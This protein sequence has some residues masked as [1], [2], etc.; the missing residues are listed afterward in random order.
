MDLHI[1]TV[2]KEI[3]KY[4]LRHNQLLHNHEN[5]GIQDMDNVVLKEKT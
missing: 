4:T 1:D 3:K 2:T 5:K